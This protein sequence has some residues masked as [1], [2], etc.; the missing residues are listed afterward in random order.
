[1]PTSRGWLHIHSWL[2]F[3]ASLTLLVLGLKIWT[4]TLDEKNNIF[5]AYTQAT[6]DTIAALQDRVPPLLRGG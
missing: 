6:P 5:E 2:C 4:L 1:M 3:I